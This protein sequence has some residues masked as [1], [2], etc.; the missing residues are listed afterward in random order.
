MQGSILAVSISP[1]TSWNGRQITIIL[2]CLIP[3]RSMAVDRHLKSDSA[4]IVP[5]CLAM[6]VSTME[7]SLS[8]LLSSKTTLEFND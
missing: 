2:P 1:I 6:S 3:Y 8:F 7:S 4:S 5:M